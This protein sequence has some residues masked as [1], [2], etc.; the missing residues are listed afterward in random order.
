[1][2]SLLTTTAL[3]VVLVAGIS[4]AQAQTVITAPAPTIQTT[5][6]TVRTVRPARTARRE[7]V[8]TRTVTRQVARP[9]VI[10]GPPVAAQPLYDEVA[11]APLAADADYRAPLY[12]AAVLPAGGPAPWVG[13][14][15]V[16]SPYIY[17]YVYEPDRILVIDPTTNITVQALPR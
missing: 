11:P 15:G 17:R 8:T 4:A 10:A 14:A 7:V 5:T 12:D 13:P 3:G 16:S 6:E 1:M 2:R 9:A